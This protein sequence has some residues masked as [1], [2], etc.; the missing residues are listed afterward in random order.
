MAAK[1]PLS[2]GV[3]I[4]PLVSAAA[5]IALI[6]LALMADP[7][8]PGTPTD[9]AVIDRK[10]GAAPALDPAAPVPAPRGSRT[11]GENLRTS[12]AATRALA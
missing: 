9:P 12:S 1:K 2:R 11:H 7:E 5:A 6:V 4:I 3:L 8:A 10:S